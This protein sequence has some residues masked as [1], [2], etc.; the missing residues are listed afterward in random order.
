[1]LNLIQKLRERGHTFVGVLLLGKTFYFYAHDP[2]V[3]GRKPDILE[4]RDLM[5]YNLRMQQWK[6]VGTYILFAD[7]D[8]EK[9]LNGAIE[10]A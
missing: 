1:M 10:K 4:C 6:K 3:A 2:K 7:E 8:F 9:A 5:D